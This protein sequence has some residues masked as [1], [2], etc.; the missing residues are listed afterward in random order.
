MLPDKLFIR[1]IA[2]DLRDSIKK[3]TEEDSLGQQIIEALTKKTPLPL[4][5]TH[6][7]WLY[8][9]GTLRRNGKCYVPDDL[10]LRK[11]LIKTYHEAPTSGHPGQYKTLML[12]MKDYYWPGMGDMTKKF[13]SGCATCQR[14]KPDTHPT[15]PGITP[16]RS[17]ATRPFEQISMD[18]ITDLPESQGYDSILVVVDQGLTKGVIFTPCHKTIDALGTADLYLN[19][20][21]KRFGLPAVMISDRGPQFAAKAFQELRK[22]L[23]I[24]HRMS[25]AYHP[26]TDRQTEQVNQELENHLRILCENDPN[27][28]VKALPIAEFAHN[29]RTHEARHMSPF[30][31]MYGTEPVAIPIAIPRTSAPAVEERI[32]E[33]KRFRE[34]ALAAHE[35]S[36]LKMAQRIT[37]R[38]KPFKLGDKVW[39][40][41]KNL[42]IQGQTKK[43]NPKKVGP[44]KITKVMGP[45][46]YQLKLPE[47]WRIH[48]T[49]HA[50]L[51]SPYRENDFHGPNYPEP[52]PDILNEEEEWE[53]EAILSH[54]GVGNR[55]RYLV[56]WKGY[57]S[58]ENTWEPE[59]HLKHARAILNNYKKRRKL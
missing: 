26:Q 34:E 40:S 48:N 2:S 53:V 14:M 49:F 42:T 38:S 30:K 27:N 57:G 54:K 9:D 12:L 7:D 31:I 4:R 17:S 32:S 13:V 37:Q 23:G 6:Q 43:F 58:N 59:A 11:D 41:T 24:D 16:I 50:S 36:K 21:Y 3:K 1:Y 47:Q 19:H 56:K 22:A 51:L 28:W 44:F 55:R 10:D 45:V 5:G 33:I 25:T 29:Q 39:L 35:L 52:P 15:V 18:F 46:T 8:I 20:V